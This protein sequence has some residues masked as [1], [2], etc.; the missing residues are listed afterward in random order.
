MANFDPTTMSMNDINNIAANADNLIKIIS[1]IKDKVQGPSGQEESPSFAAEE[2]KMNFDI[3]FGSNDKSDGRPGQEEDQIDEK[4]QESDQSDE[5]AMEEAIA[6]VE[7]SPVK[8]EGKRSAVDPDLVDDSA[9]F[10]EPAEAE[11]TEDEEEESMG[12]AMQM[13]QQAAWWWWIIYK[14]L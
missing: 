1:N 6:R 10:R 9:Q 4:E 2:K 12:M 11:A 7:E 5:E 14:E 13:K 3:D 8:K